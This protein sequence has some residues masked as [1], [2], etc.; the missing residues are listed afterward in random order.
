VRR[1]DVKIVPPEVSPRFNSGL[2]AMLSG[3]LQA[4]IRE[5]VIAA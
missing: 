2:T 1:F 4:E 5:R 3:G